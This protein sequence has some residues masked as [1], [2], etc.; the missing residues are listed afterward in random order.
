LPKMESHLEARLWNDVFNL[1]QDYIGMRRGTIRGTCLIE[2]I[3]AAFEMDEVSCLVTNQRL[4]E[5]NM[6]ID[7]L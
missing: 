1:A 3:P 6:C 5:A 7:H 4:I 2:T